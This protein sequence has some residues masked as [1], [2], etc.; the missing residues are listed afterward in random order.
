MPERTLQSEDM[1]NLACMHTLLGSGRVHV[2]TAEKM[3]AGADIAALCR[4]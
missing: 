4:Y 2:L 1:V 3:P